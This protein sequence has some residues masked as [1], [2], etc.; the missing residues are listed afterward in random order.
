MIVA[1]CPRCAE[2][3]RLPGGELPED[4]HARCPWCRESFPLAEVLQQLP[5]MLEVMS[6]DGDRIAP[7][8]LAESGELADDAGSPAGLAEEH[9]FANPVDP[10]LETVVEDG[11]GGGFAFDPPT[12][13]SD[14]DETS[15][16]V[17]E[18]IADGSG[19][20]QS[21][22][23]SFHEASTASPVAP[24]RVRPSPA[25]R[26]QKNAGFRT[27][28]GILLGG[29][30]ALPIA[31]LLLI[32]L[33]QEP[34]LGFWPFDGRRPAPSFA[35][36]SQPA[37]LP[38]DVGPDDV[39]MGFPMESTDDS[40]AG[41]NGS[42][43]PDPEQLA[44]DAL[45]EQDRQD[46]VS[47]TGDD[48]IESTSVSDEIGGEDDAPSM[49]S[50]TQGPAEKIEG[51]STET[52]TAEDGPGSAP[53]EF[54][55]KPSDDV[56]VTM[57]APDATGDSPVSIVPIGSSSTDSQQAESAE[58]DDDTV[59]RRDESNRLT[60][61]TE[62]AENMIRKLGSGELQRSE[63]K[64]VLR[65]AYKVIA[66]AC[67]MAPVNSAAIES[68]ASTIKDSSVVNDIAEAGAAWLNYA[69]R[70]S[71]GIALVGTPQSSADGQTIQLGSGRVVSVESE[72]ELP[73][74]DKVLV[75]GRI[76]NADSPTIESV[77]VDALP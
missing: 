75:M 42:S 74:T 7:L 61:L 35:P 22:D 63:R 48:E 17:E 25:R 64:G 70:D 52:T 19:R 3:C 53:S 30:A 60:A 65:E 31:G 20:W 37:L 29:F 67:E 47:A 14:A 51:S 54:P 55:D 69:A 38:D 56:A 15:R 49:D 9:G 16:L 28:L 21:V 58:I 36:E 6:A 76:T 73:Q 1:N 18:T 50:P 71:Q 66:Q 77:Y 41:L 24:M 32:L 39:G 26:P 40:D 12:D 59:A 4:A 68:L 45:M 23:G 13:G 46:L 43:Q 10:L 57:P 72:D 8:V 34:D 27:F 62:R 33:G 11:S 5:P 2:A 44:I